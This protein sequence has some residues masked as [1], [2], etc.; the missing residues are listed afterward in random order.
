MFLIRFMELKLLLKRLILFKFIFCG[1][2][3]LFE[4]FLER[5][6]LSVLIFCDAIL[7]GLYFKINF[8]L[9]LCFN[10]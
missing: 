5:L 3:Y 7:L 4:F 9:S 2:N 8:Y 10:E 1:A 6:V